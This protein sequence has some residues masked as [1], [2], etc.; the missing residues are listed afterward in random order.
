MRN[1]IG[2]IYFVCTHLLECIEVTFSQPFFTGSYLSV[3]FKHRVPSL[4]PVTYSLLLSAV[5]PQLLRRLIIGDT[6]D[7]F[8]SYKYSPNDSTQVLNNYNY[9]YSLLD[10]SVQPMLNS[11][12]HHILQLHKDIHS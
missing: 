1:Y 11:W 4:P 12:R 9:N 5:T 8:P 3:L 10:R 6:P 7:H 2:F